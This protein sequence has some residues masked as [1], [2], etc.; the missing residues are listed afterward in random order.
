MAITGR[1]L[2]KSNLQE[3]M[4]R[5]LTQAFS[6]SIDKDVMNSFKPYRYGIRKSWKAHNGTKM[7]RINVNFEVRKW[8]EEEHNQAGAS[9]PEWWQFRTQINITDKLL[10]LLVMRW[11]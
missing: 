1:Q 11:S 6:D 4:M 5:E 10:T 8:L 2:G 7:H 3:I 9:N